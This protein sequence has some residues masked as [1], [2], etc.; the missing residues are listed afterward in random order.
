MST[1]MANLAIFPR[2]PV[3]RCDPPPTGQP[4]PAEA[5]AT[6]WSTNW[7]RLDDDLVANSAVLHHGLGR[8][9]A[10]AGAVTLAFALV[11]VSSVLL[12]LLSRKSLWLTNRE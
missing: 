10:H 3:V 1:A 8:R 12:V 9:L 4:L 11:L 6:P 5:V 2:L 7:V